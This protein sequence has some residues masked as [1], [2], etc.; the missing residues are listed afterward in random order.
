MQYK[1]KAGS[2]AFFLHRLTGVMLI[3]YLLI[4]IFVLTSLYDPAAFA[5][6]MELLSSPVFQAFEYLLFL[7]ILFHSINGL[8]LVIVEWTDKGS[9][10]HKKM[11]LAVY[12]VSAI[13][14]TAMLIIFL[15]HEPYEN[16]KEKIDDYTKRAVE[17]V[18][19]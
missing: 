9:K 15:N 3:G 6:E 5:E 19:R 4:H 10:N 16:S 8:R 1:M 17:Q 12:V 18:K 11:V 2:W 13:L 14:A 7:P